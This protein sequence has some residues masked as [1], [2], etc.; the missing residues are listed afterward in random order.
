M[1]KTS[2][3]YSTVIALLFILFTS[4]DATKKTVVSQEDNEWENLFNGENLDGWTIKINGFAPGDNHKNTFRVEDGILKVAY[5]NYDTFDMKFG[6]LFTDQSYSHYIFQVDYMFLGEGLAD[7]PTW[8]NFNSGAML[9]AQSPESMRTDQGFPVCI[10]AQFLGA[11][12]TA[13]TQT[14]NA[15]TPGTHISIN[16]TL[17]TDHI[18]DSRSKLYPLNEWIRFEA[19]VHGNEL[20]IHRINGEEVIR[21]SHPILDESDKD[22]LKLIEAGAPTKLAAGHIALQAEGQPVW[23][24]NIRIKRLK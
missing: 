10:E 2:Y 5:D 19:E 13:G 23:F 1:K 7:A 20:I 17:N 11:G 9:H 21:Y 22:A 8:T 15:V 14:A 12:A 24:K 4:C 16:D 18:I 6:H 3:S